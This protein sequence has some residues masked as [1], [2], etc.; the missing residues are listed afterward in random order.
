M[1]QH[2]Q[3]AEIRGTWQPADQ[4]DNRLELAETDRDGVFAIRDSYDPA[5][6]VFAT[7]KQ[8][9]NLVDAVQKGTLRNIVRT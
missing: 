1:G 7:S 8:L 2:P 5:E 6:V 3:H 9:R 4:S